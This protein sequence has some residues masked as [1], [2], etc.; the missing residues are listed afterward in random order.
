VPRTS[1]RVERVLKLY[2]LLIQHPVGLTR[3]QLGLELALEGTDPYLGESGR[4]QFERDKDA[5]RSMGVALST[6]ERDDDTVYRIDQ[7]LDP[8]LELTAAERAALVAALTAVRLDG[9]AG[10]PATW[11]LGGAPTAGPALA[12]FAV[13]P[14]LGTLQGAVSN[15]HP[16]A[17][18]HRDRE[19]RL[20]PYGILF[21]DGQWYV[22][23]HDLDRD[24]P[25]TFRIDRIEGDPV[26]DR[27]VTFERP[28]GFDARR[29]LEG[30]PWRFEGEEPVDALV[31]VHG[32]QAWWVLHELGADALEE[33][34][35]DG[36]IVVRMRVSHRLG[37]RNWLL[38]LLDDA[39]VLAPPELRADVRSWLAPVTGVPGE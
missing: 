26:V 20:H 30:D 33:R 12:D 7:T 11:K 36:S 22:S 2:L 37:F 38:G 35:P 39:V 15:R 3:E 1:D 10:E 28:E 19:R 5:L 13:P 29:A 31:E 27:S 4:R 14:A 25:R 16:V 6:D 21:R 32:T 18:R 34:R 9:L 24:E 23:G 8:K 17:F